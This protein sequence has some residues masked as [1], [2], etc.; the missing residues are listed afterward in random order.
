MCKLTFATV[1]FAMLVVSAAGDADTIVLGKDIAT[2]VKTEASHVRSW[3]ES[4]EAY[5]AAIVDFL[6]ENAG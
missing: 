4:P 1:I 3:N 6:I 5:K 2:L